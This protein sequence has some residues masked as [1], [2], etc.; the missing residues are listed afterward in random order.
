MTA[1]RFIPDRGETSEVRPP[2]RQKER[3]S[4]RGDFQSIKYRCKDQ[5]EKEDQRTEIDPIVVN[6]YDKP[7]WLTRKK[8][9]HR[10]RKSGQTRKGFFVC[11]IAQ[12]PA[13]RG[14]PHQDGAAQT[15]NVRHTWNRG[16]ST[17]PHPTQSHHTDTEP[18]S[19][20]GEKPWRKGR[21]P[22]KKAETKKRTTKEK[23][24]HAR[25]EEPK[26]YPKENQIAPAAPK[27]GGA[28]NLNPQYPTAGHKDKKSCQTGKGGLREKVDRGEK[29]TETRKV[30]RHE[31]RK[32]GQTPLQEK[33]TDT[34]SGYTILQ[35]MTWHRNG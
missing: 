8:D 11:P 28:P 33:W 24:E 19:T 31:D 34:K 20:R 17:G 22:I 18:T 26:I 21:R 16:R 10:D 2:F 14:E 4:L 1:P 29:W 5:K 7:W 9:G 35:D 32:G 27:T 6:S 13:D 12:R 30:D 23:R 3:K 25:N 15:V